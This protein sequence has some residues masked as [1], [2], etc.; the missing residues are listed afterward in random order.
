MESIAIFIK[1]CYT[2]I[3]YIILHKRGVKMSRIVKKEEVF[4]GKFMMRIIMNVLLIIALVIY[5]VAIHYLTKFCVKGEKLFH[6]LPITLSVVAFFFAGLFAGSCS[7]KNDHWTKPFSEKYAEWIYD[8]IG[9][10]VGEVESFVKA[11][12]KKEE[13]AS[14]DLTVIIGFLVL[15]LVV[16]CMGLFASLYILNALVVFP[17][18]IVVAI[19]SREPTADSY[20]RDVLDDDEWRKC[21]C[22]KC[23]AIYSKWDYKTSNHRETQ[24]LGSRQ[25]TVTDKYTDGIDTLYVDREETRYFVRT[26]TSFDKN[27]TCPRCKN[28]MVEKFNYTSES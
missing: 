6:W 15:D 9:K 23:G 18:W 12:Y 19:F 2:I 10:T 16:L 14:S 25:V 17:L 26:N 7:Y 1:N 13:F 24:S 4:S 5:L 22:D 27:F 3:Y 21:I 8:P 28:V 11:H 20:V